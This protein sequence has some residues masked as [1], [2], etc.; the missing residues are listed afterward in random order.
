[1]HTF[2]NICG[3]V[4]DFDT[5]FPEYVGKRCEKYF[6]GTEKPKAMASDIIEIGVSNED[7][8][9][10]NVGGVGEME[11]ELYAMNIPL[12]EQLP[13]LRR[14]MTHGVAVSCDGNGFVFTAKSGVGK[15]THAFLWQKYLGKERVRIVNG[16]KPIVWFR[17]DGEIL[18]CGS[19]W[20]GKERMDENVCVPLRGICLLRRLDGEDGAPRIFRASREETLDFL[21]HQIYLPTRKNGRLATFGMLEELYRKVPIYHLITDMSQEGVMVSSKCLLGDVS[22]QHSGG[23]SGTESAQED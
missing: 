3:L 14:M 19:P 21:M 1:M 15:S 8:A 2:L 12:S 18:V 20:S 16:D 6:L 10:S 5:R 7:I 23:P 22:L 17:E 11:A 13:M 4:I 9:K